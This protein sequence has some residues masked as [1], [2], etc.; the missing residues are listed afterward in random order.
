MADN[1]WLIAGLGN[2][3]A[4]YQHTRHNI[5][6]MVLDELLDRMGASYQRTKV[7]AKA[8]GAQL[9]QGGPKAVFA[10]SEGYMN[11]SGEPFRKVMDYFSVPPEQLLVVHDELDIDF[12]RLKLK[13]GG[14]EGG[15]NG[16]KSITQHLGGDRNYIRVRLGIGRPPGQMS[17]ADYVLQKFS[18]AEQKELPEFISRAADAVE[19]VLQEDLTTAQ[20]RFH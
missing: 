4:R 11:T 7:G 2:P 16:L 15:H 1:A 3:G 6:Q 20:N 19:S 13:R 9:G 12:G 14:S 5:G 17:S 8:V 18:A 10:I